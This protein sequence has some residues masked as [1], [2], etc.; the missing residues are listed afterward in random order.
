MTS[1]THADSAD[2]L[3]GKAR[4]RRR[5]RTAIVAA[6]QRLLADGDTPSIAQIAD[7]ADVSRRTI[8][9]HFSSLDQLLLDATIGALSEAT[10]QDALT[11]VDPDRSAEERV[12]S[13]VRALT[14]MNSET[15]S[16]GRSLLR[17]TIDNPPTP[18]DVPR[19]GYRRVGWIEQALAP[20]RSTLDDGT[21]ER[22]VSGLAMVV[23]WEA[24]IVLEDIRGLNRQQRTETSLWAA[25]ALIAAAL[26]QQAP[27]QQWSPT[28]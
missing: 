28:E 15:L 14:E 16:L 27:P 10:V 19:R 23:G 6:T 11:A 2:Q 22:L 21:F 24:L 3:T 18:A 26:H 8:Y 12:A 1:G 5:T 4:Q 17:L 13:M 7:E 25:H 9:Q 20:L